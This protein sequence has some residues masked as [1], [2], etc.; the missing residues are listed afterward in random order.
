VPIYDAAYG[1]NV[2]ASNEPTI[3][4]THFISDGTAH[5]ATIKYAFNSTIEATVERAITATLERTN[6]ST[7]ITAFTTTDAVSHE[8]TY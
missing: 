1:S 3:E 8:S 6:V 7:I 4:S 5:Y 2:A